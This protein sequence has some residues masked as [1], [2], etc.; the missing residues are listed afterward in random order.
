MRKRKVRGAVSFLAVTWFLVGQVAAQEVASGVEQ[1]KKPEILL[2]GA[3]I[4]QE[5]DTLWAIAARYLDNP[6]LWP[7]IWK[8]N[9]FVS[10]PDKIF[11]GDPLAIPGVTPPPKPVAE[12][13]PVPPVAEERVAPPVSPPVEAPLVEAPPVPAPPEVA[14]VEKPEEVVVGL[15]APPSGV[16]SRL[17]LECSGFVAQRREIRAVGEIIR[18]A[19]KGDIRLWY[20]DNVFVNMG[21]RKVQP[22]DRFWVIRPTGRVQH[23]VTGRFAGIKVRTLGTVEIVSTAGPSPR[24]RIVYNCEDMAAGDAL[25]DVK[26]WAPPPTGLSRPTDLRVGGYIVGSKSEA[27]SLGQGDIVYV[28]VGQEKGIIP[29]DE[30]AIYR[31][32]LEPLKW[33]EMVVIRTSAQSAVGL[34]IRSNHSLR[35]GQQIGLLRRRP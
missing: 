7:Q 13:P 16:I 25:V 26:A 28:D 34:V 6:R 21:G 2:E 15:V 11:P 31:M 4:V 33:G 19:E 9:V 29:G 27:D 18:S 3:Y 8:E 14:E 1:E 12:A 30:F 10:D 20:G 5:G 24:A 23:P 35:V 32:S 17:A 22:G